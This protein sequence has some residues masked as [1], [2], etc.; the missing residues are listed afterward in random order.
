MP[1][2]QA[3]LDVAV[4][5]SFSEGFP[6]AIGEAMACGVPCVATDAGG[7]AELLGDSGRLVEVGDAR[8][9]AGAVGDLL[10]LP[11]AARR[12]LGRAGRERIV[13]EFTLE[14]MVERFEAV[15]NDVLAHSNPLRR[16]SNNPVSTS[17]DRAA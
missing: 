3:S 6:N 17:F 4:L 16:Q 5:A 1:T 10:A 13:C 12:E 9:L 2:W 14:R 7:T 8:A 15:W 11:P